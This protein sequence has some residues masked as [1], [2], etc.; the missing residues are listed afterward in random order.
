MQ[1]GVFTLNNDINQNRGDNKSQEKVQRQ[2]FYP[3]GAPFPPRRPD[4]DDRPRFQQPNFPS[5]AP[6]MGE[7]PRSA[8]PNFIPEA[9]GM[10]RGQMEGPGQFQYGAPFRDRDRDR[11]GGGRPRNLRGCLNRFT[12]IWLVNG[13]SFWFYP[14]Y[15]DRQFVQ[16]FRWRRNRWEFDRI[17]VRRILFFRCF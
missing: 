7:A 5:Q 15:V 8:P 12:F 1:K 4:R 10:G 17:N 13:N 16:G 3:G 9:P 6:G 2:Q 14:T 11:D